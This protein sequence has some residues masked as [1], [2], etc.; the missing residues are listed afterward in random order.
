M[1]EPTRTNSAAGPTS[2]TTA[3]PPEVGMILDT[4]YG[5]QQVMDVLEL[6]H[7]EPT[8][9]LRPEQGG[10]E[11]TVPVAEFGRVVLRQ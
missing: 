3:T 2:A 10:R 9:Y 6:L 11:W 4:V 1:T 5:R 7:E 8:V